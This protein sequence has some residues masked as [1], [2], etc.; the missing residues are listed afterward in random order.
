[1]WEIECGK[2]ERQRWQ[3]AITSLD[4]I[5]RQPPDLRIVTDGERRYG[6]R[7]FALCPERVNNG[8]PGRP[9]K[10]C[11]KG[12]HVRLKHTGAHAHKK[13][14]KRPNSQSPWR[15]PPVTARTMAE[16]D[17]QA[18]HAAAFFRALRRQWATFRRKT[19]TDAKATKGWQRLLRV[20]WVVHHFLRV[21]FTPREVPAVALGLLKRRLSVQEIFQIQMV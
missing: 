14:R 6:H 4:K 18:N 5:A 21:H 15:A 7:L 17:I 16:T 19:N 1:M 3:K 2:T 11:K 13:G 8:Q 12:V 10:T 9:K 20:Y